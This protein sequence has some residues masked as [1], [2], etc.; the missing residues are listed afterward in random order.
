M[1]RLAYA[2]SRA[3]KISVPG[4]KGLL[5]NG[6]TTRMVPASKSMAAIRINGLKIS[7]R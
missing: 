1:V 3:S 5:T 2:G 7:D 6:K 4:T